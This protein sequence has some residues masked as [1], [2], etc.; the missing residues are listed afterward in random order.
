MSLKTTLSMFTTEMVPYQPPHTILGIEFWESGLAMESAGVRL[1]N[2]LTVQVEDDVGAQEQ[3][4]LTSA[5]GFILAFL[6]GFEGQGV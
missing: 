5:R 6:K 4:D 3:G 1:W 2:A